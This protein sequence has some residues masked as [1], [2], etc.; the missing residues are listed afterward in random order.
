M[1]EEKKRREE[2]MRGITRSGLEVEEWIGKERR[3]SK[4]VDERRTVMTRRR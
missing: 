3:V 4:R 2:E 1:R